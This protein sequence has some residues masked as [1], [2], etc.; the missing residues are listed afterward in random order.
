MIKRP[1]SFATRLTLM[2]AALL[3]AYAGL[4]AVLGRSVAAEHEQESLQRLSHGLAQHIVGHW[5]EITAADPSQADAA[6]RN[7]LLQMLMVVNPGIQ[8]YVLDADGR[9]AAYIGEPGTAARMPP[10]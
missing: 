4:I 8:A 2:L 5:P 1:L 10:A 6:A 9:V 3:L 7:A